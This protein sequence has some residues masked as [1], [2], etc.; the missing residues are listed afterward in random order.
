M[1]DLI[2]IGAGPAGLTACLYA[3]RLGLNVLLIDK[4]QPGGALYNIERLENYPG[5]ADG[6]SG[7]LLAERITEQLKQYN[8]NFKQGEIIS[9]TQ[10]PEQRWKLNSESKEFTA[11]AVIV[12][13]GTSPQ[14]LGIEGEVKFTGKGVSY[15]ALCDGYFFKDKDVVVIGGGN[16][17]LEEAVFLSKLAKSVTIIHR[18]EKFRADRILQEKA[19]TNEKIKFLMSSVCTQITGAQQVRAVQVKDAEGKI[20]EVACEGIFI[21]VGVRPQTDF[22]QNLLKK[23]EGGYIITEQNLQSSRAGIFACGDSRKT[24]LRQ[25]ITACGEGALAAYAAGKYLEEFKI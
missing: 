23:D 19:Q 18:R 16:S 25:V 24:L 11:K 6:I 8:F 2:I 4:M 3:L 7:A 5:F 12:A 20:A 1:Y 13:T 17:A 9:I 10:A 14:P 22:L 21:F 15:C